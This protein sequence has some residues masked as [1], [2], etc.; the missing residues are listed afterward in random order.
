MGKRW[1]LD[2]EVYLLEALRTGDS[3]L[4]IA[5]VLGRSFDAVLTRIKLIAAREREADERG[6]KH[7]GDGQDRD[8][9]GG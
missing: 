5:S 1:S 2:D 4:S 6:Q 8:G 3:K 9:G 7:E